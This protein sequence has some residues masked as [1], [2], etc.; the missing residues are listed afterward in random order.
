M[1]AHD[2]TRRHM[3]ENFKSFM[4]SSPLM[5]MQA[6]STAPTIVYPTAYPAEVMAPANVLEF[7]DVAKTKVHKLAYDY[8]PI[9][10]LCLRNLL[11]E[12]VTTVCPNLFEFYSTGR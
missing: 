9:N 12:K 3:F 5:A 8:V 11:R 6:A 2:L 4:R 7:E 10:T 1:S